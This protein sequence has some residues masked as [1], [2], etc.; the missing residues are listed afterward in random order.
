MSWFSALVLGVALGLVTGFVVGSV[1][2]GVKIRLS[3]H[4]KELLDRYGV[5]PGPIMRTLIRKALK[6]KAKKRMKRRALVSVSNDLCT[7]K[8]SPVSVV[9]VHRP[10]RPT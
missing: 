9:V 6:E 3:P 5:K 2:R 10:E 4:L 1:V 7:R 8:L